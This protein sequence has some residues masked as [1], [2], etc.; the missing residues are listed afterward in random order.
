MEGRAL[1]AGAD[2]PRVCA[3]PQIPLAL[4]ARGIRSLPK[5]TPRRHNK[6]LPVRLATGRSISVDACPALV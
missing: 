1:M 5:R 4:L 3:P 2:T 6:Q